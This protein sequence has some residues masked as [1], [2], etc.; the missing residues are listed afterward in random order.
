MSDIL[1]VNGEVIWN[2][3]DIYIVSGDENIKQ[4][5][6]LRSTC[7]LGESGLSADYG[8]R[9]FMQIGK[10]DLK[11]LEKAAREAINQT[12]GVAEIIN[13]NCRVEDAETVSVTA[14]LRTEQGG[15]IIA[16]I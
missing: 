1:V 12:A 13:I 4:Q 15:T 8:S 6:Y 5:A 3:D 16:E 2:H 10:P 14:K 11:R 9:I 7:D